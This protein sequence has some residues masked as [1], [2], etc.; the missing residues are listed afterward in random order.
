MSGA[1]VTMRPS[2]I[3]QLLENAIAWSVAAWI[4]WVL[5]ASYLGAVR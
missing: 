5:A 2:N 3:G 1:R 4:M